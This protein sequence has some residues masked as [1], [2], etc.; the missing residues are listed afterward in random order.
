MGIAATLSRAMIAFWPL[1]LLAVVVTLT[2]CG[3]RSAADVGVIGSRVSSENTLTKKE[4]SFL[5]ALNASERASIRD[6]LAELE[7]WDF[8]PHQLEESLR[9]FVAAKEISL[10]RQT[11]SDFRA[12]TTEETNELLDTFA[13]VDDSDYF[14]SLTEAGFSKWE[15]EDWDITPRRVRSI[16]FA[17]HPRGVRHLPELSRLIPLE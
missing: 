8:Q 5:L 7:D 1:A 10:S 4:L 15:L 2:S 12:L 16:M 3:E 6:L 17:P 11:S 13:T 9:D 14:R